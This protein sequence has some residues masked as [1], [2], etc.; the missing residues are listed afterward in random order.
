[1]VFNS[2]VRTHR[3]FYYGPT[4]NTN[5]YTHYHQGWSFHFYAVRSII[6]P[7]NLNLKLPLHYILMTTYFLSVCPFLTQYVKKK[8]AHLVYKIY[9]KFINAL[10][11]WPYLC[12]IIWQWVQIN[13]WQNTKYMERSF[14]SK[15]QKFCTPE[16][17]TFFRCRGLS[18]FALQWSVCVQ[19]TEG[20]LSSIM[21]ASIHTE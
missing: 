10:Y 11:F 5:D 19:L 16:N 14:W 15:E 20:V 8:G 1:M 3:E 6:H 17:N 2:P 7:A 12:V 21:G 4:S 9:S 13:R 18:D